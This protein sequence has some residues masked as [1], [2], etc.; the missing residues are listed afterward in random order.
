MCI[1]LDMPPEVAMKLV[2]EKGERDYL[3][4]QE[5]IHES[6]IGHLRNTRNV[7]HWLARN[8]SRWNAV[9]CAA[10]EEPLPVSEIADEV[11]KLVGTHL[12]I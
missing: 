5:D 8:R 2:R 3:E 9:R 1:W 11:W 12:D 6:S 4:D 10:G 7:Y